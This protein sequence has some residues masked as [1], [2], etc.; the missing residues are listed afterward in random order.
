M[1]KTGLQLIDNSDKGTIGDIKIQPV[2]KDGKIIGGFAVGDILAQNISLLLMHNQGEFKTAPYLGIGIGNLLLDNDFLG[3]GNK[4]REQ[5]P[6][7]GL[8]I[9]TLELYE[10]KPFKIDAEYES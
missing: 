5:F 7:D 10:N 6:L 2:R 8:K 3:Y 9:K 1:K 4:I